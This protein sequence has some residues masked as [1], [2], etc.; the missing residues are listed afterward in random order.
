[1]C[2]VKL[3]SLYSR[4]IRKGALWKLSPGI[5]PTVPNTHPSSLIVVLHL[6][7]LDT[8]GWAGCARGRE[9]PC[10]PPDPHS[11]LRTLQGISYTYFTAEE[12]Q[13]EGVSTFLRSSASCRSQA[14]AASHTE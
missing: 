1:M 3:E 11:S 7:D 9:G 6:I 2:F 10:C 5:P 13:H 12:I 4:G 14:Q 8:Q